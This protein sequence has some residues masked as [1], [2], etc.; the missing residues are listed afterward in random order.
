MSPKASVAN[1]ARFSAREL[2]LGPALRNQGFAELMAVDVDRVMR[3]PD[4]IAD[5]DACSLEPLAFAVHSVRFSGLALGD[6][7]LLLGAGPI[8]LLTLQC[9][10]AAGASEVYVSEPNEA[11]RAAALA[12]GAA[13]VIDPAGEDA[14]AEVVRR[15]V[16]GADVAF[17]CAGAT[18]TL[19]QALEAARIAGRVVV[20]ALAWEPVTCRPV[21]W[22]GREVE[23]KAAY[24]TEARDW[25]IAVSL[26]ERGTVRVDELRSRVVPLEE[27]DS[28]FQE[29][30]DPRTELIQVIVSP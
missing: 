28:I 12:L 20:Q 11:R 23:M 14:V 15:T 1:P 19:Q 17:E 9:A 6:R 3:I 29:L 24:G 25:Q 26:L 30:L 10:L 22:V 18:P 2:G 5:L 8:G 7:V 21:D 13:A 4:S 16:I 27:I